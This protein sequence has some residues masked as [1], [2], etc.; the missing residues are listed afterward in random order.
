MSEVY[1]Y[2]IK[3][4]VTGE[5]MNPFYCRNED[6]A[7]RIFAHNISKI[8]IWKENAEQFE[9]YDLGL[10]NTETGIIIGNDQPNPDPIVCHPELIC[11]GTD[12]IG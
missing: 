5:F 7:K 8:E 9:L 11:K 6:E 3:D 12:L 10:L 4:K 1:I 2:S